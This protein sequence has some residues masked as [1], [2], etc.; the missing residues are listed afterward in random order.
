MNFITTG[1]IFESAKTI[2]AAFAQG[3]ET[4]TPQHPY[5]NL[6][7]RDLRGLVAAMVD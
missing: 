6:S 3:R 1:A 4:I 7:A 2:R 5:A